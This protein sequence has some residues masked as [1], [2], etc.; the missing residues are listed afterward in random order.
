MQNVMI[1]KTAKAIK[2]FLSSFYRKILYSSLYIF[3]SL[4]IYN[5][6]KNFVAL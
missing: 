1:K 3:C 4:D 5:M 2:L 6:L